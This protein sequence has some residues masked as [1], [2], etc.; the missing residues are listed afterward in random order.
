MYY[1]DIAGIAQSVEQRTENP[2]VT[3]SNLVPGKKNDLSHWSKPCT[4]GKNVFRD[5]FCIKRCSVQIRQV[6]LAIMD[7]IVNLTKDYVT[8][9]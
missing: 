2:C 7:Q 6:E 8:T 3:S 4:I 9:N 5:N 1:I